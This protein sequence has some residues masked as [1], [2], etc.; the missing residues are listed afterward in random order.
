M[1]QAGAFTIAQ[2]HNTSVVHG[3]PGEAIAIGAVDCVL[4]AN[5]IAGALIST[6]QRKQIPKGCVA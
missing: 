3:M 4:P 2:D 5:L 6:V 1:R